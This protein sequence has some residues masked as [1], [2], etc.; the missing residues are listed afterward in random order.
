V[1]FNGTAVEG[2]GA[3]VPARLLGNTSTC[4]GS[5]D[6]C[7]LY[8]FLPREA[9]LDS[10]SCGIC[11]STVGVVGITLGQMRLELLNNEVSVRIKQSRSSTLAKL[12]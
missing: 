1:S 8:L 10:P 11:S 5:S 7:C 6:G 4:S 9:T 3:S 2:A 12:L